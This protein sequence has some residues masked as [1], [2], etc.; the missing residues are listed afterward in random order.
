MPQILTFTER[1]IVISKI[2]SYG[3]DRLVDKPLTGKEF[4]LSWLSN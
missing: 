2:I 4:T 3:L 1:N